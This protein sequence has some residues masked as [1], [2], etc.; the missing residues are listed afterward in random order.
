[1]SLWGKWN[2]RL[3]YR[4]EKSKDI[5]EHISLVGEDFKDDRIKLIVSKGAY[6]SD[7]NFTNCGVDIIRWNDKV[8]VDMHYCNFNSDKKEY[9]LTVN[10]R[11][12]SKINRPKFKKKRGWYEIF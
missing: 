10:E 5:Y 6:I 4:W 1:M 12:L 7:C 2:E 8:R 3:Y 11:Y 9:L